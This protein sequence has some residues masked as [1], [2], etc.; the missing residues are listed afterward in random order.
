MAIRSKLTGS[1]FSKAIAA[2]LGAA[3]AIGGCTDTGRDPGVEKRV[4]AVEQPADQVDIAARW[5]MRW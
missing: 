2:S 4:S 5:Q 1:L 3:F